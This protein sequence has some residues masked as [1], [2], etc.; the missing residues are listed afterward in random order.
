MRLSLVSHQILGLFC[1]VM[2]VCAFA[3][4]VSKSPD[5]IKPICC[6]VLRKKPV[7]SNITQCYHV[8]ATPKCR[9]AVIFTDDKR[10]MYCI[11][12]NALWLN[13]FLEEK[14]IKCKKP[15]ERLYTLM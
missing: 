2:L 12:P 7:Q 14:G 6:K 10:K 3:S 11:D 4:D 5:P 1:L 13:E 8:S 15:K 9:E